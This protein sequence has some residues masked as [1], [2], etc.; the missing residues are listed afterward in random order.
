MT[1]TAATLPYFLL[2]P[3]IYLWQIGPGV[4]VW[5]MRYISFIDL[6]WVQSFC[7]LTGNIKWNVLQFWHAFYIT[8]DA[9][10]R[11]WVHNKILNEWLR[12]TFQESQYIFIKVM[13]KNLI[14]CNI[15]N[16]IGWIFLKKE[17]EI[18]T[19][20]NAYCHH[21]HVVSLATEYNVKP[22]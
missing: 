17:E 6:G 7:F 8:F 12:R 21:H 19:N 13:N 3:Q 15:V 22:D 5:K 14:D 18:S 9:M 10:L 4:I 11:K 2:F 20:K 1:M 16:F